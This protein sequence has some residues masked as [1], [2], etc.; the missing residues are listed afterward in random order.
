MA[1]QRLEVVVKA[2]KKH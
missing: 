2:G 1:H